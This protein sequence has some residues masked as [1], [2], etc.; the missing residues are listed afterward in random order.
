MRQQK[1]MFLLNFGGCPEQ[2]NPSSCMHNPRPQ[3]PPDIHGGDEGFEYWLLKTRRHSSTCW[4]DGSPAPG[5]D[6]APKK[7]PGFIEISARAR[8]KGALHIGV[9]HR[10]SLVPNVGVGH[11]SCPMLAS[12]ITHWFIP[13]IGT[14]RCSS[15]G[16]KFGISHCLCPMLAFP[17]IAHRFVPNIGIFHRSL[18][19]PSVGISHPLS[20]HT[21]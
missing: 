5:R 9:S 6:S 13:N 20:V 11:C 15:L 1:L 12:P 19:I 7:P 14:F 4:W 21:Q 18:L 17:I 10:T 3:A 2:G 16:P 8:A